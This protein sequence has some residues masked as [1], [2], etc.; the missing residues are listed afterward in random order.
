MLLLSVMM[1]LYLLHENKALKLKISSLPKEIDTLKDNDEKSKI[2]EERLKR[3]MS[4]CKHK[5]MIL[6][7]RFWN[8]LMAKKSL[9]LLL[10]QQKQTLDKHVLGMMKIGKL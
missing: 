7:P 9:N 8:L 1:I 5:T 4:S 10:G 2:N 6:M 3:E